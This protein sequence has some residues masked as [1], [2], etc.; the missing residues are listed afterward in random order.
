LPRHS[1]AA[2]FTPADPLL[3]KEET[4]AVALDVILVAALKDNYVYLL[5]EPTTGTVA[6]VD[7]AESAPVRAALDDRGWGLDLI[8]NTHHHGDH[9][10]GNAEL[11][12]FYGATI[13]GPAAETARIPGMDRTV[14]EGDTVEVGEETARVLETPGHTTGHVAFAF[15]GARAL[16]CGDTLFSL[17]CGRMFEGTPD[18]M[19]ASLEKLRALPDD[20]RIYCGH[21][22]TESNARF[23]RSIDPDNEALAAKAESVAAARRAGEPTIPATLGEEKAAN[24]FLRADDPALAAAVGRAGAPPAEVFAEIRRRKDSF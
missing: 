17:G 20:T 13:I 5:R 14:A 3:R 21:E 15:E 12:A 11:K 16:F 19:W 8:L 23:A 2:P 9:I 1:L 22:Y 18:Q 6:V 7:P 10:G 24:P 4:A